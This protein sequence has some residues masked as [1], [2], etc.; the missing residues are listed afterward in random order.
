MNTVGLDWRVDSAYILAAW[1]A[2]RLETSMS[3]WRLGLFQVKSDG[4]EKGSRR[5]GALLLLPLTY[6]R[7]GKSSN[8][9]LA[10]LTSLFCKAV[11]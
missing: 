11:M 4:A 9:R 7:T 6:T 1:D 2:S 5:I 10:R 3:R 8:K